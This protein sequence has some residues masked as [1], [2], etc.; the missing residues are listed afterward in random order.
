MVRLTPSLREIYVNIVVRGEAASTACIVVNNGR[1]RITENLRTFIAA[2]KNSSKFGNLQYFWADQISMNQ[3]NVDER[4]HQVGLMSEIYSNATAVHAWVGP[5]STSLTFENDLVS[6]LLLYA[7]PT[8]VTQPDALLSCLEILTR[9][10]W[11]RLWIV[12]ELRLAQCILI[13]YGGHIIAG[14]DLYTAVS[15]IQYNNNIVSKVIDSLSAASAERFACY[16]KKVHQL[17]FSRCLTLQA[18]L[19]SSL[20]TAAVDAQKYVPL[21]EHWY[22]VLSDYGE[23]I[24]KDSRD[25]IFGLQSLVEPKDRISVNYNLDEEG[26]LYELLRNVLVQLAVT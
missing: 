19:L 4:N 18:M 11:Y 16:E 12:Q 15:F 24:C 23:N 6:K 22:T 9:S 5:A 26:V 1:M 17:S 8:A 25:K 10:Y 21:P 14:K 7:A 20:T 13:R 3:E 2:I